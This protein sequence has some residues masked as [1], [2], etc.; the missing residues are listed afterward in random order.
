MT[1]L[2]APEPPRES[3][4]QSGLAQAP[5][6][7][8][9]GF[10]PPSI[11]DPYVGLP[12]NVRLMMSPNPEH[13]YRSF[14]LDSNGFGGFS[15][16]SSAIRP[17][18]YA[19]ADPY[20]EQKAL[21]QRQNE[22][23]QREHE[24]RQNRIRMQ[25]E[26]IMQS[27]DESYDGKD[28]KPCLTPAGEEYAKLHP[29]QPSQEIPPG[30]NYM[31]G[32]GL[33]LSR[34]GWEQEMDGESAYGYCMNNPVNYIDPSGNQPQ[35]IKT[36]KPCTGDDLKACID[37]G[38]NNSEFLNSNGFGKDCLSYIF[39][40][41]PGQQ[42]CFSG[43]GDW[44]ASLIKCASLGGNTANPLLLLAIAWTETH[45]GTMGT[46]RGLTLRCHDPFGVHFQEVGSIEDLCKPGGKL[47]TLEESAC[48]TAGAITRDKGIKDHVWGRPHDKVVQYCKYKCL[49]EKAGKK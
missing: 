18:N 47:P 34:V 30:R 44:N 21:I 6:H 12:D 28:L 46:G 23:I 36:H 9:G 20:A 1:N 19:P 45:W 10:Q 24:E 3:G 5:I 15:P 14:G 4:Y 33:W 17:T 42:S 11:P 27:R 26:L 13:G 2:L 37:K 8:F 35:K 48:K 43:S 38:Q 39:S 7:Q 40:L 32:V 29:R 31:A 41:S 25:N 22:Q 49:C 16:G